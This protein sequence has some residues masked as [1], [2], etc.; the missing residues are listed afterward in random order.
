MSTAGRAETLLEVPGDFSF[1]SL[2][3]AE[4]DR[5]SASPSAALMSTVASPMGPSLLDSDDEPIPS[6]LPG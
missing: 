5:E 3:P 4:P 1:D 6:R 2:L